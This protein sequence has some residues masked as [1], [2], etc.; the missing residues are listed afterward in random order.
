M[1]RRARQPRACGQLGQRQLRAA[2]REHPEDREGSG[3]QGPVVE[4][5]GGRHRKMFPLRE[6]RG[7][8]LPPPVATLA[9]MS[10][11]SA[12]IVGSGNI[13]T[14]LM[15]KLLGSSSVIP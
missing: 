10:P 6:T 14:D 7:C 13:G 8:P 2:G 15:Y 4:R 5:R 12:A 3:E 1:G 11:L 9:A